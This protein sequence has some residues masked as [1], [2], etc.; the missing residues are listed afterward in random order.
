MPRMPQSPVTTSAAMVRLG[1]QEMPAKT[2]AQLMSVTA[3]E[4]RQ[5]TNEGCRVND[6][7]SFPA[8]K[9]IAWRLLRAALARA[10]ELR[11]GTEVPW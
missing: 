2:M 4:L 10:E 3:A 1:L 9:V 5:W 11:L 7:G 6:D 8:S